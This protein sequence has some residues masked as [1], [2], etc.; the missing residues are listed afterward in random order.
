[1]VAEV[2]GVGMAGEERR[3]RLMAVPDGQPTRKEGPIK[4]KLFF[5]YSWGDTSCHL[6]R[7]RHQ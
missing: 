1:M 4:K 6:K 5:K 7:K 3:R 2:V